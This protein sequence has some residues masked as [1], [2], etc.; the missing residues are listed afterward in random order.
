MARIWRDVIAAAIERARIRGDVL[1]HPRLLAASAVSSPCSGRADDSCWPG[2]SPPARSSPSFSTRFTSREQS[3]RSRRSSA[4]TRKPL[5]P[6]GVSSTC[7]RRSRRSRILCDRR[8]SRAP[9]PRARCRG[10][11]QR[12]ATTPALPEVLQDVSLRIGAGEVVAL[13]GPSGAGKTTVASLLPRFWDVTSRAN[14]SR[15]HR[16]PRFV[17]QRI[18][19]ARSGS[20]R[21]IRR[22]SAAPS[23]RTSPT[24]ALGDGRTASDAEEIDRRR[25][26]SGARVEFIERLPEGFDTQ[27]RRAR[28]QA[29]RRSASAHRDRAEYSCKDPALVILDEATSS[30]DTESERLV[31]E[32]MEDLLRARSTLIIA[33]RLS[34]VLRA[35]QAGRD[36]SWRDRRGR[37]PPGSARNGRSLF[38]VVPRPVQ[39]GRCSSRIRDDS[40]LTRAAQSSCSRGTA[41]LLARRGRR[42]SFGRSAG[43]SRRARCG[44]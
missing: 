22:C 32:A 10:Q 37:P 28:R 25:G 17:A 30:L 3:A 14:H 12:S 36:R 5:A 2:R 19:A 44:R 34:T 13:V 43:R 6:R 33:H 9:G 20:C 11:R 31:E 35:D 41:F 4:R 18:C 1:R 24:R 38:P 29:L 42:R 23:A 26:K 7:S 39:A 21:R 8:H 40:G 16:H 27:S 15:W